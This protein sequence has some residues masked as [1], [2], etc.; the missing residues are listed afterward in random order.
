MN[1][2]LKQNFHKKAK[3]ILTDLALNTLN[4]TKDQFDLRTNLAGPASL[5]ETTL[6][7]DTVYVQ[8]GGLQG[9]VLIRSCRSRKD[10]TG[11]VNHFCDLDDTAKLHALT[12]QL[13]RSYR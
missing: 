12:T 8:A 11:G 6:H 10:F 5:G 9:N 1:P 7:T 3:K 13:A 2:D 4:L